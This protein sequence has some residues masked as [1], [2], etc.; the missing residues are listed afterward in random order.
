MLFIDV[1]LCVPKVTFRKQLLHDSHPVPCSV[2]L[3][4]TKTRNR[5]E[6]LYHWETLRAYVKQYVTGCWTCQM[7]KERNHRPF[8]F[9]HLGS[10]TEGKWTTITMDFIMPLPIKKNGNTGILNVAVYC[11]GWSDLYTYRSQWTHRLSHSY[12]CRRFTDITDCQI[13]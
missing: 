1:K 4:E 13:K 7:T 10:P 2:H 5:I 3:G 8:G 6:H 9:L 11:R 12:L